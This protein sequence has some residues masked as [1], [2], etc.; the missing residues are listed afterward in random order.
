MVHI[1]KLSTETSEGGD[2][3]VTKYLKDSSPPRYQRQIEPVRHKLCHFEGR[4]QTLFARDL[5]KVLLGDT[6][7]G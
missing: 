6:C 1:I 5:T 2:Q 4:L 3:T 7:I